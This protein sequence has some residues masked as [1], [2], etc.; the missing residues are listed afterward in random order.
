MQRFVKIFVVPFMRSR[1]WNRICE[2]GSCRGEGTDLLRKIPD[3]KTTV[4]DP[5]LDCDL[6]NKFSENSQ[7][8]M[9]KGLSLEVLPQL[10]ESFDCI[11]IDGDH[12][13][14]T[15]Y[16]EL[17]VISERNLLRRGGVIFFHD[18][19]WPWGRRDLYYQPETIPDEFR[20]RWEQLGIVRGKSELSDSNGPFASFKKA[21]FEGGERNGV[22]TAIE[23]FLR[24]HKGKYRFFHVRVGKGLGIMQYGGG[25]R[26]RISFFAMACKGVLSNVV[27]RV[28]QVAGFSS[29]FSQKKSAHAPAPL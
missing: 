28:M 18:V 3:S 25:F 2:I 16:N 15:V 9:K 8:I 24:D 11:L 13:W 20:H 17:R 7:V 27:F 6:E 14:Y 29:F 1:K 4:I 12:N 19:E 26:D 10:R 21:F 23:D 22:L 5:C